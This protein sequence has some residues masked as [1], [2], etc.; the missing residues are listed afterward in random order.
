MSLYF[1]VA[2]GLLIAGFSLLIPYFLILLYG[3][4]QR[5]KLDRNHLRNSY[6]YQ[7]YMVA[8]PVTRVILTI[9]LVLNVLCVSVGETFFFVALGTQYA[10]LMAVLLPLGFICLG[11]SHLLPLS[12]YRPHLILA[13][14]GFALL[15]VASAFLGFLF[16]LPGKAVMQTFVNL[17]ISIIISVLGSLGLISLANPWLKDWGKMER[18][19]E[20][21]KTIYVKPHVNAFALYEWIFYIFANVVGL[22]LFLSLIVMGD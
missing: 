1:G 13:G 10:Y 4:R 12:N 22:L 11:I 21:G 19:E 20:N 14:T 9:L 2:S 7:F 8:Q 15:S 5:D 6:P 3:E 18:A 16:L 17:P